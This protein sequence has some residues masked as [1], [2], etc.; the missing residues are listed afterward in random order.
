MVYSQI[1]L[2]PLVDDCQLGYIH[3]KIEKEMTLGTDVKYVKNLSIEIISKS[4]N[5]LN[6]IIIIILLLLLLL[7]WREL[8]VLHI[9]SSKFNFIL[10]N[11]ML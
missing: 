5:F 8:Y 1:W 9:Y 2:N 3:H 4:F 6:V 7:L 10:F 11:F